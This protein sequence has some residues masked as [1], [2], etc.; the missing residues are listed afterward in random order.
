[1]LMHNAVK[2]NLAETLKNVVQNIHGKKSAE[3]ILK[4][5]E[6]I[7]SEML[8][9][10]IAVEIIEVMYTGESLLKTAVLERVEAEVR[11]ETQKQLRE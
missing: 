11:R 10:D 7:K 3:W 1:M 9:L 8:P 2:F 4:I 6:T 5:Y